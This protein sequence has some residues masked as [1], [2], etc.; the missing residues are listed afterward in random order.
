MCFLSAV[1][2]PV[3]TAHANPVVAVVAL[4]DT[5]KLRYLFRLALSRLSSV[6]A[7]AVP[8]TAT[9]RISFLLTVRSTSRLLVV[10]AE[11]TPA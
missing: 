1:E 9:T 5:S 2:E 4:A 3:A 10:V 6:Q 8:A 7:A 11:Q